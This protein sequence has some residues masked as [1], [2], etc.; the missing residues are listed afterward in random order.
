MQVQS[1]DIPLQQI[2]D[3]IISKYNVRL[4]ILR[5]D[6]NHHFV[7]GNKLFKLKYNIEEARKR[8]EN[9]LLT[10]GGAFSNHIA[11]TAAAGQESGFKTIGVIR[12]EREEKL[13][14]T[15]QFATEQGMLLHY[16]SREEYKQKHSPQFLDFLKSRFKDFYL[17]PEGGANV[18]GIE[19]CREIRNHFQI[20]FD[21]IACPC[22]TGTTLSGIILSLKKNE[23]AFGFQVLKGE[24]YIRNE[25]KK[26]LSEFNNTDEN[27][28]EIIE[29]YHFGGY[30]KRKAELIAFNE[31][32]E[33]ENNIPLDF[34][35]TGKM[36]FG[37]YD[38]IKKGFFKNG[39]TIIAVHTGGLQ[40]NKGFDNH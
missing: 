11:A 31:N 5:A 14:P 34:I 19:G 9:T 40:G 4:F 37:I 26:W 39:E 17:I 15:L 35:Y 12:G 33:K 20:P 13:N 30:A 6:L 7:S 36:M 16:I 25:V 2:N 23:K 28:W 21:V 8:N 38:L 18:K 1:Y 22:G 32:F 29:D 24:K 27:N 10:F 3:S